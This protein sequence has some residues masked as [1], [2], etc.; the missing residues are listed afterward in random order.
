MPAMDAVLLADELTRL[1]IT[2][3]VGL[4]DNASAALFR[5]L[6]DRIPV[7]TV[8]RE[9]EAFAIAA[10][11]WL[12]GGRPMV[13]IQNTG[14]LESGD[15]LRGTAMRMRVPLLVFVTWRGHASL[16]KGSAADAETL[17]RSDVDSVA[18][19]TEGTL[20]AW[21]VSYEMLSDVGGVKAALERA[22]RLSAPTALLVPGTIDDADQG[23]VP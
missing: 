18:V 12:G 11:L 8:T 3:A 2:H 20:R 14:L 6:A 22:E 23:R 10:G 5:R 9:G 15:S 7:L 16:G 13:L 4:P 21:G 19:L 17:S 1:G